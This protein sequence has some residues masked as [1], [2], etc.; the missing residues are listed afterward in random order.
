MRSS[1]RYRAGW[2]SAA[3]CL[4]VIVP[5]TGDAAERWGGSIA[6][7]SDYLLRGISQSDGAAAL[8]TDLHYHAPAG[9]TGGTRASS[10]EVD[11][12]EGRTAELDVYAGY[13]WLVASNWSA[14]IIAS[15]Y[16]YPWN[17]PAGRY[18]YDDLTAEAAWR[19]IFFVT[20]AFSPNTS[21]ESLD[22]EVSEHPAL[23]WELALRWPLPKRFTASSGIGRYT[24]RGAQGA[25]YWYWSG[26]MA[27]DLQPL[28][29]EIGYFGTSRAAKALFERESPGD[30]WAVTLVWQF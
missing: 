10:V 21:R 26:G 28:Q 17:S 16:A 27:Y 8:L 3:A 14:T 15:H 25:T 7:T 29:L 20:G 22:G 9:W 4:L 18:D 1:P 23:S 12:D 24:L 5:L 11:I 19:D 2:Q 13:S 30:H 6:L